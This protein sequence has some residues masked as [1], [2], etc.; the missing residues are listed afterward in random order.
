MLRNILQELA[1][2]TPDMY[3]V[4]FVPRTPVYMRQNI[5]RDKQSANCALS[6]LR[7]TTV[8]AA[9]TVLLTAPLHAEQARVVDGILR[10][11]A[12]TTYACVS[13]QDD[14]PASFIEPWSYDDDITQVRQRLR[15][16]IV[17]EGGVVDSID[18]RYER[19]LFGSD[20]VEFYFTEND[21]IV[22]VRADGVGHPRFDWG[23]NRN[24]VNRIRIAVGCDTVP[25]LRGRM[26][27]L[28]MFETPFDEFA[29]SLPNTDAFIERSH[30]G[31][32]ILDRGIDD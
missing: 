6:A 30:D 13:T 10:S 18:G 24:R 14:T 16:T 23:R 17:N 31:A 29:P 11:C 2:R 25:V 5:R 19:A 22:Q 1:F 15:D 26:G 32:K 20:E 8:A 7:T 27:R 12:P 4:A 21:N 28:H 3:P 9:T